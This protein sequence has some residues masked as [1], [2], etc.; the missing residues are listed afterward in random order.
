M[1]NI[2]K[3]LI[4][5][6]LMLFGTKEDATKVILLCLNNEEQAWAMAD[7]IAERIDQNQIPTKSECLE[8]I[9]HITDSQEDEA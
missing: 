9:V 4:T 7:W 5:E 1:R 3:F 2:A 6:G 8:K